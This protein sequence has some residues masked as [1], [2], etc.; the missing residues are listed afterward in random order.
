MGLN[1]LP[2]LFGRETDKVVKVTR[3]K[4]ESKR[5]K[6]SFEN[7][8]VAWD[9]ENAFLFVTVFLSRLVKKLLENRMVQHFRA[10]HEPFHLFSH[11]HRKVSLRNIA[12]TAARGV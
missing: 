10:H 12:F 5:F 8:D 11:V 6:D 3:V 7:D 1:L 2:S 9:S 4:A